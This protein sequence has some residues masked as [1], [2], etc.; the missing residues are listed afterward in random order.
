MVTGARMAPSITPRR[1]PTASRMMMMRS[2]HGGRE[3]TVR[4]VIEEDELAF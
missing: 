1:M 3:E 2:H 4:E